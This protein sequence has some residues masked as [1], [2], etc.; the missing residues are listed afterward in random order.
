[1]LIEVK[2]AGLA[3]DPNSNMPMV[4][5]ADPEKKKTLPIWIGIF[6]ASAIATQ[7]EGIRL[8]R[9][10]THDL[11][12]NV[13]ET[14]GAKVLRVEIHDLK[15]NTFYASLVVQ[16]R[17]G[18]ELRVDARPSDA[19]AVALRFGAPI[20][21]ESRLLDEAPK[22]P[23]AKDLKAGT[24]TVEEWAELLKNLSDEAFGK[25]KM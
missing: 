25:Y 7:L 18:N 17:E 22:A 15:E 4:L 16:G 2:V 23:Q 3:L 24:K 21:V 12:R 9:P 11:V 19:I 8:A 20:L 1:M 6:E 13:I 10:M 14:V 5:L